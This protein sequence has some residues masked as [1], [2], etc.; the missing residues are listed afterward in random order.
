MVTERRKI[1]SMSSQTLRTKCKRSLLV[2]AVLRVLLPSPYALAAEREGTVL[3]FSVEDLQQVLSYLSFPSLASLLSLP[4]P[5]PSF[6]WRERPEAT[7]QNGALGR[8]TR[9]GNGPG[10]D[11]YTLPGTRPLWGY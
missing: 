10:I 9:Y 4:Q 6:A 5:S 11:R 2:G 1:M 3:F 7:E 8:N